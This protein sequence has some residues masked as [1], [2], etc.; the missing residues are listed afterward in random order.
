MA[1]LRELRRR[2]KSV[3]N[4]NGITKAMEIVASV[5]YRKIH[6]RYNGTLPY[7]KH[8]ERLVS[9][10]LTE[11]R[12]EENPLFEKRPIKREL[13]VLITGDRGLCGS[14]NASLIKEMRRYISENPDREFSLYPIGKVGDR[15]TRRHGYEV[16]ESWVDV[17]YQFTANSL[18]EK[19][20][21]LVQLFLKKQFD[22]I[23]IL[24]MAMPRIGVQEP[25]IEKFLNLSYLLES[26]KKEKQSLEYLF[27]PEPHEVLTSLL[28]L[29]IAQK[30]Y[31][32]L[33]GSITAEY[34]ARMMAMKLATDN[35]R[36]LIDNLTLERNK[37][38]QAMI[39]REISEIIGGVEALK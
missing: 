23:S 15:Y 25:R 1:S 5:R 24:Y 22:Q 2:I 18:R 17:G 13:V 21:Y 3:E 30:F 16:H 8:L 26:D 36:E 35:G 39:T 28:D 14:F 7:F 12:I 33:L 37:V 29:L 10:I 27:E 9:R 11:E 32:I 19:T 6:F 38:R 20:D 34:L 4:I 31:S